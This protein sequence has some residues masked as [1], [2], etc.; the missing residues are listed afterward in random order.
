MPLAALRDGRTLAWSEGGDPSCR[1]VLFFHG[2]P[3]TGVPRGAATPR[4]AARRTP[5]RRQPARLRRFHARRTVVPSRRRRRP[6]TRGRAGVDRFGVLG[7]SV[8]GTFALACAA[9]H[10]DR[11][12]PP[13]SW[14]RRARHPAWTRPG[15]ATTSTRPAWPGT[16]RWRT[17]ASRTT[18]RRCA[19]LPR[20]PVEVAPDDPDDAAL[21]ERWTSG[22]R[23]RT[24]SCSP[25]GPRRIS[26]PTRGRRCSSRTAT[27]ATRRWCSAGGPSTSPDP[28][29]GDSLV[30]RSRRQHA[31]SQR[32][33][34]GRAPAER[35]PAPAARARPSREPAAVVAGGPA[36]RRTLTA[37]RVRPGR[38][39]A[40]P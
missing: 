34:A 7:M 2:C 11:V 6:R 20:V 18:S 35:D 39:P 4:P 19:R 32:P 30:R 1:P 8:G 17:A 10:P 22:L 26:R 28:L 33:L 29:P 12:G 16:P 24:G 3:D 36:T 25:A 37:V 13:P 5:G 15:P 27:S 40:A 21:A 23:P 9:Y 14:R 31:P 38:S